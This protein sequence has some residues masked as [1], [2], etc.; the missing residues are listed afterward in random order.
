V[1]IV[2][3]TAEKNPGRNLSVRNQARLLPFLLFSIEHQLTLIT[4]GKTISEAVD[5]D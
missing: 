4:A 2:D 3:S 1:L 5:N